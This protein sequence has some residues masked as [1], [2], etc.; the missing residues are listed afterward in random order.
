MS[1][2]CDVELRVYDDE[3]HVVVGRHAAA[4]ES[5]RPYCEHIVEYR[6]E[7]QRETC[8]ALWFKPDLTIAKLLAADSSL[9]GLLE[10]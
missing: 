3:L 6:S 2:P 4:I 1:R 9:Q 8:W 5:I 7:A 10:E